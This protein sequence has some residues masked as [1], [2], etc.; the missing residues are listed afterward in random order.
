MIHDAAFRHVAAAEGDAI[1]AVLEEALPENGVAMFAAA[2]STAPAIITQRGPQRS[3]I[4]PATGCA[5]PHM[6]WAMPN[7]RLMVA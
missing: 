6:S 4:A 7:A 5:T 3:A 2:R 1:R